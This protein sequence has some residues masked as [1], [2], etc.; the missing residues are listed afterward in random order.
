M[1]FPDLSDP[2]PRLAAFAAGECGAIATEW[3]VVTAAVAS[4]GIGVMAM[5]STG[6]DSASGEIATTMETAP[7]AALFDAVG[8][9]ILAALDF[10]DGLGPFSGGEMR[11]V[12]GFGPMLLLDRRDNRGG[13]GSSA[14][15][16]IDPEAAYTVVTFD[17]AFIDSWDNETAQVYIDGQPV[18]TGSFTHADHRRFG[19]ANLPPQMTDLGVATVTFGE[20]SVGQGGYFQT[21][22]PQAWLDHTQ[23]VEIVIPTE[24][25]SAIEIGF[26]TNLNSN[27]T[28]EALGIDNLVVSSS[29]GAS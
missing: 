20:A 29:A 2:H 19:D 25:R 3:V 28:D 21:G 10:A 7:G 18:L 1:P 13:I 6:L 26:G 8:G 11:D 4:L 5:T 22:Q 12:P 16:E 23:P 17:M 24:G 15:F 27:H 14:T 9:T